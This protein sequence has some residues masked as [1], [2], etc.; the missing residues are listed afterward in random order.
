MRKGGKEE[1]Q[2]KRG[3]AKRKIHE[4]VKENGRTALSRMFPVARFQ[5]PEIRKKKK[6]EMKDM[7]KREKQRYKE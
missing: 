1:K 7:V 5:K 2:R 3:L 4:I 6:V